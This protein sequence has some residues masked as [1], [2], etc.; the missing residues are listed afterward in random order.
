MTSTVST[1]NGLLQWELQELMA[2]SPATRNACLNSHRRAGTAYAG[3]SATTRK[4][5]DTMY[6]RR[7]APVSPSSVAEPTG[8]V[9][10][11]V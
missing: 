3:F 4:S 2:P 8:T 6:C 10:F 5:G 1:A 11:S 7:T 9:N